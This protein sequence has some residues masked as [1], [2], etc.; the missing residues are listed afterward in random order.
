MAYI[1]SSTFFST[2]TGAAFD[3]ED[4][5]T[6]PEYQIGDYCFIIITKRRSGQI[7]DVSWTEVY[8]ST[9]SSD[10]HNSCYYK[11]MTTTNEFLPEVTGGVSFTAFDLTVLIIADADAT[12]PIDVFANDTGAGDSFLMPSVTTTSDKSLVLFASMNYIAGGWSIS[13][14]AGEMTLVSSR[15]EGNRGCAFIG[16]SGQE[17]AGVTPRPSAQL[18][19][20]LNYNNYTIAIKN[21]SGGALQPYPKGTYQR[22]ARYSNAGLTGLTFQNFGNVV[23]STYLGVSAATSAVSNNGYQISQS[24]EYFLSGTT[25]FAGWAGF[26]ADLGQNYDTRDKLLGISYLLGT[27]FALESRTTVQLVVADNLGNWRTYSLI[28]GGDVFDIFVYNAW[29]DLENAQF[30]TQSTTPPNFANIRKVGI[31]RLNTRTNSSLNAFGVLTLTDNVGGVIVGGDADKP[32][33]NVAFFNTFSSRSDITDRVSNQGVGQTL[34]PSTLQIGNGTDRSYLNL[35][36]VSFETPQ[37]F[38]QSVRRFSYNVGDDGGYAGITIK[39]GSSDYIDLRDC[40]ISSSITGFFKINSDS[41]VPS[42]FATNGL[43]IRNCVVEWIGTL[44]ANA[45]RFIECDDIDFKDATVINSAIV[46]QKSGKSTKIADG[47]NLSSCSFETTIASNN[48][49]TI[50]T[51]GDYDIQGC[52]FT[53]FTTDINITATTGT[54]NITLNDTQ[55]T[56]TFTTAGAT[57]NLLVPQTTYTLQLPNIINGSRFQIYNV[58]DDTELTNTTVSGGLGINVQYTSGVDYE[59][60]DVGRYRVTYQSGTNAMQSI[61]GI[62]TFTSTTTI[63]AIPISQVAQEQYETFNVDGSGVDEFSWDSG[64]IQVDI[65]DADNTTNIQRFGAWYYYFITTA[66][67]IEETFNAINWDSLNSIRINTLNV[68][69]TLDNTKA[70]P[71]K[72]TGGRLF[73]DDGLT[74]IASTSNSIQIDYDPVYTVETGVSGLTASESTKLNELHVINGLTVGVPVNYTKTSIIAGGITQTLSGDG[75]NNTKVQRS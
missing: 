61:E 21:S 43:Q 56:P 10:S 44:N 39:S 38:N 58:T 32:I 55:D 9:F 41:V 16:Y 70:S 51:A 6:I 5:S 20:S 11:K 37:N 30:V 31:G 54:V 40:I 68:N 4:Y 34:F 29:L 14:N 46:D 60:G 69:V 13:T 26:V 59:S 65:N 28:V 12:N 35:S 64:N 57:V 17:I 50:E 71:L 22:I 3:L 15:T 23:G 47:S 63:N 7:S 8:N 48:A 2:D 66:I 25:N 73:R 67:G 1:R 45:I 52:S 49:L 19:G 27:S 42:F 72:L 53:G 74:I 33:N 62:F 18:S 75:E 36:G 24:A